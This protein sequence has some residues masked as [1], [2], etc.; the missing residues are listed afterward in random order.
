MSNFHIYAHIYFYS[1]F[2][3]KSLRTKHTEPEP[4]KKNI[5]EN[6][7]ISEI[8]EKPKLLPKPKLYPKPS[9]VKVGIK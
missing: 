8:K 2:L 3:D 6:T 1:V 5:S 7:E 4:E 9:N